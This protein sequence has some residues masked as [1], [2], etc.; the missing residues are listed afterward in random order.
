MRACAKRLDW[1]WRG[2]RWE[3]LIL[4]PT[5]SAGDD[6]GD[7]ASVQG[8][9]G[10]RMADTAGKTKTTMRAN[11]VVRSTSGAPYFLLS[12][13]GLPSLLG[14]RYSAVVTRRSLLGSP[15]PGLILATGTGEPIPAS[16]CSLA[17]LRSCEKSWLAKKAREKS[18]RKKLAQDPGGKKAFTSTAA[19]T[20]FGSA[21]GIQFG[22]S[23]T[24]GFAR[25]NASISAK[26]A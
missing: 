9:M 14:S 4:S 20:A 5:T 3:G 16:W 21:F 24:T 22:E 12:H 11:G 26:L 15:G 13:P 8:V 7:D 10:R 25:H 17:T 19:S 6:P 2:L 18:S 1:R 23:G